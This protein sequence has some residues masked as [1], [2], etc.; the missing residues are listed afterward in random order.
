MDCVG[1]KKTFQEHSEK[2]RNI[3]FVKS[4]YPSVR[5]PGKTRLALGGI[6]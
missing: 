4:V 6:S 1:G 5:Q 2:R 3:S